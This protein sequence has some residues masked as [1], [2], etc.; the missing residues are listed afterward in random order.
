MA[1]KK[2]L[3]EKAGRALA[4]VTKY[5]TVPE[6]VKQKALKTQR[7][8]FAAGATEEEIRLAFVAARS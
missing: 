1:N 8:A 5:R 7:E 2:A 3:T 4:E 6:E